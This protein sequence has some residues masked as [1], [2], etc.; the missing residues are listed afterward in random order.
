MSEN[1]LSILDPAK[2]ARL[3]RF[4]R[5]RDTRI[6]SATKTIE[7]Y[8]LQMSTT[9]GLTAFLKSPILGFL[10]T[11]M[12]G[13]PQ[14]ATILAAQL[15]IE[16]AP[17]VMGKLQMAYDLYGLLG[18]DQQSF[19][20]LALWPLV[21]KNGGEIRQQTW[22]LGQTLEEF[23]LGKPQKIS[24]AIAMTVFYRLRTHPVTDSLL[25][26]L[27]PWDLNREMEINEFETLYVR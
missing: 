4:L 22:A 26:L 15:P 10:S 27:S 7:Q 8:A 17:V 16:E 18:G 9:Q 13:S 25:N 2:Q 12:T 24:S 3:A 14:L 20:L 11:L 6:Q 5:D 1:L 23:W 21:Q 19:D